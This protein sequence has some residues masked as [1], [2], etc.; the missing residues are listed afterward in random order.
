[1][2]KYNFPLK[3]PKSERSPLYKDI[4]TSQHLKYAPYINI[5]RIFAFI[6]VLKQ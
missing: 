6:S 2:K 1:M 5:L 4:L 3:I